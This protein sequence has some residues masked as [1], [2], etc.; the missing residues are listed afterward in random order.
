MAHQPYR[1]TVTAC[2]ALVN[3]FARGLRASRASALGTEDL[4]ALAYTA[5]VA[6]LRL[7]VAVLFEARGL[8]PASK[9]AWRKRASLLDGTDLTWKRLR[10]S[11]AL[12]EEGHRTLG[13]EPY[14][15]ASSGQSSPRF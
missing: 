8:V 15:G 1:S 11:W 5:T 2:E 12:F 3:D 4:D 7:A 10:A 14:P 13:L 9:K 6:V